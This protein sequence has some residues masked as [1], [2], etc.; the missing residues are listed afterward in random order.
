MRVGHVRV[1]A[2]SRRTSER[3]DRRP[4]PAA[5][6][7]PA[8]G[9]TRSR[10]RRQPPPP[11]P[12]VTSETNRISAGV[13]REPRCDVRVARRGLL[14]TDRRVEEPGDERRQVAVDGG[15]E[16]P[17]LREL[18][19]RRVD[20]DAMPG[21]PPPSHRDGHVR[22]DVA[23]E[24][25]GPVALLPDQ[26]LQTL[27]ASRLAIAIHQPQH[28]RLERP[29]RFS[30]VSSRHSGDRPAS[31][32]RLVVGGV[33]VGQALQAPGGSCPFRRAHGTSLATTSARTGTATS[34]T[35]AIGVVVPSMSRSTTRTSRPERIDG[36]MPP[37]DGGMYAGP[38]QSGWKFWSTPVFV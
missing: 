15:P 1:T 19:A 2:G 18:A 10:I 23:A 11:A 24:R 16:E 27:E 17:T 7:C 34:W 12:R 6:G 25:A 30:G 22:I 8:G 3:A 38:K 13:T 29:L 35:N 33:L 26:S 9:S 5:A 14:G 37:A 32:A 4:H 28:V 36:H 20:R 31:P 21:V